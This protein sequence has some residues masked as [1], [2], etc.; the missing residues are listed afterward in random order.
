MVLQY[1][2][3]YVTKSDNSQS[4]HSINLIRNL[5]DKTVTNEGRSCQAFLRRVMSKF[6]KE[7]IM[8]KQETCHLILGL[9]IV[10]CSHKLLLINLENTTRKIITNDNSNANVNINDDYSLGDNEEVES[11]LLQMTLIDAYAARCD[12]SKWHYEA[13]YELI[14]NNLL[15]MT[16]FNFC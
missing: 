8:S 10:H 15:L 4:K 14:E 5:F 6:M 12:K 7:R 3:K 13:E 9:P 16:L 11:T 2:S 1:M